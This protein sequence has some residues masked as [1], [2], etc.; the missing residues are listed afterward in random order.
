MDTPLVDGPVR[1]HPKA[2]T[3]LLSVVGY[4]AVVGAFV[5]PSVQA[6]FP[7]LSLAQVNLLADAIAVVN[8]TAV[9]LLS[10][11]WYWIRNDEVKK[12]A[13]AM[14]ASFALI[15][16][17]LSLYL[18]K[19]AG[20]GTK[21]FVL[22]SSY[23]WVPLWE[24]VYP[25]YLLML[26]IHILLSILSVPLVLYAI[27]LGVTHTPEELRT[28]TPHRRVGRLAASAWILS[29]FLGVVTYLLLNHLYA[30]E[31]IAA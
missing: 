11:G 18:P 26:A 16:L 25:A 28:E 4:A 31:F 19:V 24:W 13:R 2:V 7:R 9:V 3:A 17:F 15:L 30:W 21:E 10:L 23:A 1:A 12:H 5:V 27:V 8:S 29:L 22:E 14:I 6:L 20:G